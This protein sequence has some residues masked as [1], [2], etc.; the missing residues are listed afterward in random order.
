MS[1]C[2]V[3]KGSLFPLWSLIEQEKKYFHRN[4]H[5]L[6]KLTFYCV[7]IKTKACYTSQNQVAGDLCAIWEVTI[8]FACVNCSLL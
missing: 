2:T 4:A 3:D 1:V 6:L 8:Q 7:L 5:S